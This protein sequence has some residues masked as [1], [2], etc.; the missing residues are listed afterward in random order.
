MQRITIPE[1]ATSELG[2]SA[3]ADFDTQDHIMLVGCRTNLIE[4]GPHFDSVRWF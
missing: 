4:S 1:I 2:E 3:V